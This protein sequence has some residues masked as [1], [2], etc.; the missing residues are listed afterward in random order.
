MPSWIIKVGLAGSVVVLASSLVGAIRTGESIYMST[1]SG[2]SLAA[3]VLAFV[4]QAQRRESG[5][6]AAPHADDR[7]SD[8]V[9]TTLVSLSSAVVISVIYHWRLDSIGTVPVVFFVLWLLFM[10]LAY[11][12]KLARARRFA[13]SLRDEH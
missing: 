6:Q 10:A 5:D 7:I 1:L 4:L 13:R 8:Y 3:V 2:A 12:I 11:G 9:A